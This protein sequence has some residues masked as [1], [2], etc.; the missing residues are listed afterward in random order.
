[1]KTLAL[2]GHR[3]LEKGFSRERLLF[4]LEELIEE[5]YDGFLCGMAEG[6]DL[7]ALDCLVELKRKYRI[8]IE[9]CIPYKGQ[10]A[11]FS[12]EEK[13]RYREL[14]PWC[15]RRTV[16]FAIFQNGCYL[17]RNRYM[18]DCAQGVLAY[19]TRHTGGTAYTVN[20]AREKHLPVYLFNNESE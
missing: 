10:E 15:D 2:T 12:A 14:L 20:Y 8:Y 3:K 16:L 11:G 18:V 1:M 19:L 17:V 5:G 4:K 13:A 9:A 7:L 6:F